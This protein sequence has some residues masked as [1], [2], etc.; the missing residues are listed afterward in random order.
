M[1]KNLKFRNLLAKNQNLTVFYSIHPIYVECH[2][3]VVARLHVCFRPN[4]LHLRCTFIRA[5]L[6]SVCQ[7]RSFW[8]EQTVV[9]EE[10]VST[11][12]SGI[13]LPDWNVIRKVPSIAR[14]RRPYWERNWELYSRSSFCTELIRRL[15]MYNKMNT[16]LTLNK[17]ARSERT[18]RVIQSIMQE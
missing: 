15:F 2:F 5:F 11:L 1:R 7:K 16:I 10:N 9:Q 4:I 3:V 18:P 17:I 13:G 8:N 14:C 12:R 6:A